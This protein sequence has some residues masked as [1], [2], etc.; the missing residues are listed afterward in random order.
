[1]ESV[2]TDSRD[3]PIEGIVILRAGEL[4]LVKKP[5]AATDGTSLPFSCRSHPNKTHTDSWDLR[6]GFVTVDRSPPPR[7]RRSPSVSSV[8]ADRDRRSSKKRS[9]R[10]RRDSISSSSS[11]TSSHSSDSDSETDRRRKKTKSKSKSKKSRKDKKSSKDK[12]GKGK[13]EKK[14]DGEADDPDREETDAEIDA[15]LEREDRE[16]EEERKRMELEALRRRV[17]REEEEKKRRGEDGGV[18]YKGMLLPFLLCLH[19]L[20]ERY[21]ADKRS[22][23]HLVVKV[24]ERCVSLKTPRARTETRRLFL[25]G[26]ILGE[27]DGAGTVSRA[28]KEAVIEEEQRRTIRTPGGM[29]C[30]VELARGLIGTSDS[31]QPRGGRTIG[32][33]RSRRRRGGRWITRGRARREERGRGVWVSRGVTGG[34]VLRW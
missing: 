24:E 16:R 13:D 9:S 29:I 8:D 4:E 1:M 34:E 5:K 20:G 22:I 18:R 31:F 6:V 19:C 3:R 14:G 26:V 17:E 2:E 12:K 15:R 21:I 23:A 32:I 30:M 10:R 27:E 33:G 11:S 7:K 25:I 28:G